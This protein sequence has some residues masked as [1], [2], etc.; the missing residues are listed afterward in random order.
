MNRHQIESVVLR[1]L[2]M[3]LRLEVDKQASRDSLSQWDS[4]KHIEVIFA[5][6]DQLDLQFPEQMLPELNSVQSIV[7]AAV[8]LHAA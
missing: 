4:L 6:E 3:T 8:K 1:T 7:E 5:I 2:S